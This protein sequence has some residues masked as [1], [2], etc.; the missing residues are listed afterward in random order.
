MRYST[1]D[2]AVVSGLAVLFLWTFVVLPLAFYH[3]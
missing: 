2:I 3:T 1:E